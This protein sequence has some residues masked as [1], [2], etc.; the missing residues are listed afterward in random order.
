[1]KTKFS[2]PFFFLVMTG[3]VFISAAG[4]S[5]KHHRANALPARVSGYHE[6][7]RW[8]EYSKASQFVADPEEFLKKVEALGDNLEV[9]DFTIIRTTVSADGA[10]AEVE[11]VRTYHIFPSVSVERQR[12]VQQWK[13]DPKRKNWF[14]ISP[15]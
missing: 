8:K 15:Y 5:M 7:Y 3:I 10:E 14:L 13:Y 2:R 11:V 4:C 12:I 1:M 9:L 6:A